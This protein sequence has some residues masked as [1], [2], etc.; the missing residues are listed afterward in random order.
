MSNV[1]S[2]IN[3]ISFSYSENAIKKFTPKEYLSAN[4]LR[5]E[6]QQENSSIRTIKSMDLSKSKDIMENGD[7]PL[8]L[9]SNNSSNNI[10]YNLSINNPD[11]LSTN[12]F[13]YNGNNNQ[14]NSFIANQK[15]NIDNN[16]KQNQIQMNNKCINNNN[17]NV[18]NNMNNNMSNNMNNNN[19]MNQ[20]NMNN[21]DP[22]FICN[23]MK[24]NLKIIFN[25]NSNNMNIPPNS[26]PYNFSVPYN[27][28][29]YCPINY[30]LNNMH[31]MN[32]MNNMNNINNN[33][34]N[35]LNNYMN[36]N[37]NNN[38][39]NNQ[40][41]NNNLNNKNVEIIFRKVGESNILV[42]FFCSI[43]DK[44]KKI[45]E[46]YRNMT[47]DYENSK[48]MFLCD[49]EINDSNSLLGEIIGMNEQSACIF[50]GS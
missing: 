18:N 11:Y 20:I 37:M 23:N 22:N 7:N 14:I 15:N 9:S 47:G 25:N 5:I 41:N 31:N 43:N 16:Y 12:N 4:Q 2:P 10:K 48:K 34:N 35:N 8:Y 28:N 1:E 45:I 42:S 32:N 26:M 33:M 17:N 49:K 6:N 36:N 30:I 27:M 21:N 39:I 19:M 40:M 29:I 38:I 46:F 44:L 24:Q 3:Q 50:I 13:N